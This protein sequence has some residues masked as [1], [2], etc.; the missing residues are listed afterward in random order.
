MPRFFP[1]PVLT[2]R[3]LLGSGM[4]MA[5]VASLGGIGLATPAASPVVSFHRDA[6]YLDPT[7][8]APPHRPRIATDWADALD[9]EALFR[10]GVGV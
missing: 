3:E 5:G 7:G 4:V 10:L 1:T 6:P 2:R 8:H 9:D